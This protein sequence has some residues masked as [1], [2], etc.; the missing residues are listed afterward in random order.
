[1]KTRLSRQS[2]KSSLAAL[3]RSLKR[4]SCSEKAK[5]LQRFFKTGPGEYGEGDVFLGITVPVIRKIVK[6]YQDAFQL[7]DLSSLAFSPFHEERLTFLLILV[8]KYQKSTQESERKEIFDF[9]IQHQKNVN[10]WDLVDLSAPYISGPFLYH[11]PKK[12]PLLFTWAKSQSLWIRR[13]AILSTFYFIRQNEWCE[14]LE[15]ARIL[16]QDSED[17]IHKAVGWMLREIGKRDHTA[18]ENFLRHHYHQMPRTMLRYAIERFPD[19]KR[20]KYL[21]GTMELS[22][23]T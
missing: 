2:R 5:S 20:K 1:M 7:N 15:L 12:R 3:R 11:Y 17:L 16:L 4:E 21:S 10:N 14:T 13:I 22:T 6:I 9:Y 18:E 8:A 23:S 19:E